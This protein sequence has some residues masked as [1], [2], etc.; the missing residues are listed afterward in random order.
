MAGEGTTGTSALGVSDTLTTFE[1]LGCAIV[2]EEC[3]YSATQ[4]SQEAMKTTGKTTP[5][6]KKR[7]THKLRNTQQPVL[8]IHTINL[9]ETQ[10]DRNVF[11]ITHTRPIH[12]HLHTHS[13]TR[14]HTHTHTHTH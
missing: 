3:V 12:T 4:T 11:V 1:A 13:H 8:S 2:E 5:K 10:K 6:K 7:S 9:T 14:T